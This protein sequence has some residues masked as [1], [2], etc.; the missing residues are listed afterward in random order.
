MQPIIPN[1][2]AGLHT[3]D[4]A[5]PRCTSTSPSG[6]MCKTPLPRKDH[7][8]QSWC[9]YNPLPPDAAPAGRNLCSNPSQVTR[10]LPPCRIIMARNGFRPLCHT[11]KRKY[12]GMC[13][14]PIQFVKPLYNLSSKNQS[15][16]FGHLVTVWR[17]PLLIFFYAPYKPCYGSPDNAF[18]A[19]C[20][21]L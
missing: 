1:P 4:C 18:L 20:Q 15:P 13:A 2:P 21:P 12:I 3:W 14:C 17:S 7:L 11:A 9:P 19:V 5:C 8:L 16:Q 10:R 6:F